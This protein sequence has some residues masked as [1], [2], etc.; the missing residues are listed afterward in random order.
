MVKPVRKPTI[1]R[2][3]KKLGQDVTRETESN[4][5]QPTS[6][7]RVKQH[8]EMSETFSH[9]ETLSARISAERA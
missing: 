3:Q 1:P 4:A 5:L 8:G 6:T 2:K 7:S 9:L